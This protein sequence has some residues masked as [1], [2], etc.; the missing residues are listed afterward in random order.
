MRIKI[1]WDADVM[2]VVFDEE[3]EL[4]LGDRVGEEVVLDLDEN[5]RVV[6]FEI[7]GLSAKCG[8]T[9]NLSNL[10]VRDGEPS[11]HSIRKAG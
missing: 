7:Q 5:E 10:E 4:S 9:R 6:G 8:G 11:K 2:E 1:D 3:A